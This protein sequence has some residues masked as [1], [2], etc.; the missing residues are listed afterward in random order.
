MDSHWSHRAWGESLRLG[1]AVELL[2]DRVGDATRAFDVPG[3]S[4]GMPRADRSAFLLRG[5]T[6]VA[7]W[8][9]GRDMP[10]VDAVIAAAS[11]S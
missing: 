6:V 8:H 11:A 9:L 7:S 1:D 2:S 10:D 4:N 5:D 3:V